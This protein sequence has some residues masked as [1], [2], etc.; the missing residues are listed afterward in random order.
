MTQLTRSAR[1]IGCAFAATAVAGCASVPPLRETAA[2]AALRDRAAACA[3]FIDMDVRAQADAV[4]RLR[5]VD[6]YRCDRLQREAVHL[7]LDPTT[8]P[9]GDPRTAL[10]LDSL[11]FPQG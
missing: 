4:L 5:G 1:L 7:M 11:A 3:W 2:V 10:F 9:S 6:S 8:N